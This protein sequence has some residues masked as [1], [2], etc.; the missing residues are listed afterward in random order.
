[1]FQ[2]ECGGPIEGADPM[3]AILYSYI[4]TVLFDPLQ[5]RV[6]FPVLVSLRIEGVASPKPCGTPKMVLLRESFTVDLFTS[7]TRL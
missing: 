4:A 2:T 1:M 3:H 7:T 6:Y 5:T